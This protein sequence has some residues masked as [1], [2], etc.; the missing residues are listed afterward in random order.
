MSL[1]RKLFK[2]RNIIGGRLGITKPQVNLSGFVAGADEVASLKASDSEIFN[3]FFARE[4]RLV[5]K[6][7][8]YLQIYENYFDRFRHTPLKF[9]E[10]G[11]FDGGSLDFWRRYFGAQ[12]TIVGI[13]INPECAQRVTSPN[14]VR[15]GSQDDPAFLA[16]ISEEFGPFDIV[17]DDGSH[18]GWHQIASFKEL[19]PRVKAGG[20]YVIEDTH[21]SYWPDHHGGIRRSNTAIALGKSLVDDIHGW[22]HAEAERAWAK[23]E[24]PAIHFYDSVIVVEKHERSRPAMI[25]G[26]KP[27]S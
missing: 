3:H 4:G 10:I 25:T 24:I 6:W 26:G 13:D 9:L 15:I 21:T 22:Y 27:R 20:L 8:H 5:H 2:L 12:A 18:L 11:V 16:R 19:F 7:A 23:S 14:F 17:L 1:E